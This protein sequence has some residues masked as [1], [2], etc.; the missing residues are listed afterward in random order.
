MIK[1]KRE[2]INFADYNPRKIDADN[3]KKLKKEIKKHG[4]VQPIVWNARSGNI[5]SGHRRL[6]IID[7]LKKTNDYEIQ[8]AKIDVD[9]KTEIELNVLLNNPSVQG[10]WD[11]TKLLDLKNIAP[12]IDYISDFGFDKI[13][14]EF[15][16]GAEDQDIASFTKVDDMIIKDLEMISNQVDGYNKQRKKMKELHKNKDENE[17]GAQW[18]QYADYMLTF[19][20]NNNKDKKEFLKLLSKSEDEKFLKYTVLYDLIKGKYKQNDTNDNQES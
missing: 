17:D 19:V 10:E 1:I 15:F 16:C 9:E 4:L 20:F 11:V 13:D 6:E 2:Q 12:D 3:K 18:V 8:V 5:V 7:E 14:L